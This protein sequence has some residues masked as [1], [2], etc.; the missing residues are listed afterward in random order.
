MLTSKPKIAGPI[1]A[2]EMTDLRDNT[3]ALQAKADDH[4]GMMPRHQPN[5]PTPVRNPQGQCPVASSNKP[6]PA[7][8]ERRFDCS[9]ADHELQRA[10][11]TCVHAPAAAQLALGALGLNFRMRGSHPL[12]CQSLLTRRPYHLTRH[13]HC[14][15][16]NRCPID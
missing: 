7:P 10:C 8:H 14:M 6:R 2:T 5:D 9:T 16:A 3:P 4:T 13:W 1:S 11:P 12:R 15:I